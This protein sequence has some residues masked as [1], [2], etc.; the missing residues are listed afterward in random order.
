M[1]SYHDISPE[2]LALLTIAEQQA[3][4]AWKRR[5]AFEL[6]TESVATDQATV[7]RLWFARWLV[8]TG[9]LN[10]EEV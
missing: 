8:E 9:R 5:Y 2:V 3:L 10:E 1:D 7:D 4:A 6:R